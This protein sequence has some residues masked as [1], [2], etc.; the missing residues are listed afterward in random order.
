MLQGAVVKFNDRRYKWFCILEVWVFEVALI[1]HPLVILCLLFSFSLW[2]NQLLCQRIWPDYNFTECV[3]YFLG[4]CLFRSPALA[5]NDKQDVVGKLKI[6]FWVQG[7]A[8]VA[9]IV[10]DIVVNNTAAL[11][12]C[13][14]SSGET[15]ILRSGFRMTS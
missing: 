15:K 3:D 10:S 14:C 7:C 9:D 12:G 6:T 5:L 13:I 1:L 8:L 11:V 2:S 4:F